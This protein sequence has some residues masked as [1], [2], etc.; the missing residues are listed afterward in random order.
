MAD[1][2]NTNVTDLGNKGGQKKKTAADLL[3]E[4]KNQM[5]GKKTGE[6]KT[7]ATVALE[8][9]DKLEKS[10]ALARAELQKLVDEYTAETQG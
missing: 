5:L 4:I 8:N 9:I 6:F 1:D 3:N 2:E 10:L 7:K